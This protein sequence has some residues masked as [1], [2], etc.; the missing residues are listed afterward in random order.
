MPLLRFALLAALLALLLPARAAA[1]PERYR[2]DPAHC[3]VLFFVDHLGF[4]MQMGRFPGVEGTVIFDPEDWASAA[5]EAKIDAASLYLGDAAWEKKMRSDEFFDVE[6]FPT[7]RYVSERVEPTGA[8][9]AR[10][11]GALTLRGVTRPVVLDLTVNRVGRN[12][13]NL[14][15][16]AGFSARSTIRRSE[17]GMTRLKAA[18]GDEVEIRLEIEAVR[19]RAR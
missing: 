6:R 9:T 1:A 14:K 19:D 11:H 5:V 12:S 2:L 3:Q 4:S 7:L 17:F 13:F 16:T 18:V 15:H 10:V 8:K